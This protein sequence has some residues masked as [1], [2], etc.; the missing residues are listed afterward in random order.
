VSTGG[1]VSTGS[2]KIFYT[3]CQYCAPAIC[4]GHDQGFVAAPEPL[5]RGWVCP[6]CGSSRPP[7][8]TSC[9]R[10]SMPMVTKSKGA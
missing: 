3:P 7:W 5:A 1:V 4:R 9:C 6:T 2:V 8:V 10:V